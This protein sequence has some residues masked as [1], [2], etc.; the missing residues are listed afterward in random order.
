MNSKSSDYRLADYIAL[1]QKRKGVFL[2][3]FF[4]FVAAALVFTLTAKPVYRAS[5][6]IKIEQPEL[7]E[8]LSPD[9]ARSANLQLTPSDIENIRTPDV[10]QK[11]AVDAGL[12]SARSSEDERIRQVDALENGVFVKQQGLSN[13]VSVEVEMQ[14]PRMAARF[15]N[16]IVNAYVDIRH[17]NTTKDLIKTER[18]VNQQLRQA[19]R[20]LNRSEEALRNYN[21]QHGLLSVDGENSISPDQ[22]RTIEGDLIQLRDQMVD[23]NREIS[24]Y[25]EMLQS[26]DYNL[27]G[28]SVTSPRLQAFQRKLDETQ[29]QILS[30]SRDYT[31]NY[32]PLVELRK[33]E[34]EIHGRLGHFLKDQLYVK[35]QLLD[36]LRGRERKLATIVDREFSVGVDRDMYLSRLKR[37]ISTNE[38][39]YL[40]LTKNLKEIQIR[41]QGVYNAV[42]IINKAVEPT[43]AIKPNKKLNAL[44]GVLVGLMLGVFFA[45]IAEILDTSFTTIEEIE[46]TLNVPVLAAVPRFLH[47]EPEQHSLS[48]FPRKKRNFTRIEEDITSVLPTIFRTKT[49]EAE[50]YRHLYARLANN[51]QKTGQSMFL[52]TSA[53]A[54]EGKTITAINLAAIA[55]ANGARTMLLSCDMRRPTIYKRLQISQYPGLCEVVSSGVPLREAVQSL[56]DTLTQNHAVKSAFNGAWTKNL[57]ILTAGA[58]T[59]NPIEVLDS[60]KMTSLLTGLKEEYD[61]V[62]IDMPPVQPVS[63]AIVL[64]SKVDCVLMVIKPG[65]LPSRMVIR[66]KNLLV[67]LG[68]HIT[69]IVLNNFVPGKLTLIDEYI[70]YSYQSKYYVEQGTGDFPGERGTQDV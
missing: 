34:T 26:G 41:E 44:L 66:S 47:S 43:A 19:R 22:A 9:M 6:L 65:Q 17:E 31:D 24:L 1:L 35:S 25:R 62:F 48:L 63:D 28:D 58:L 64:G 13:I 55:A 14:D 30:L 21:F 32:P 4:A 18:F 53:V 38:G 11:A 37:D 29:E 12:I 2:V 68:F 5:A 39:V 10:I 15:A 40:L 36:E 16:L 23:L 3:T 56:P 7:S 59:H 57:S 70:H 45:L 42:K 67:D 51:R 54:E 27:G 61:Y 46:R 20:N 52:I 50:A 60:D 8:G 49:A 69:G 33:K